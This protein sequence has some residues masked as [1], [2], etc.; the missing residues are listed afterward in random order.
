MKSSVALRLRKTIALIDQNMAN[1]ETTFAGLLPTVKCSDCGR[2][3]EISLM[4]EHIC[5]QLSQEATPPAEPIPPP[6]RSDSGNG[7]F[8][9]PGRPGPPPRIDPSLANRPFLRPVDVV[10]V[11]NRHISQSLTPSTPSTGSRKSYR[12]PIRSIKSPM[13]QSPP[14]PEYSNLD[15]A[16]PPFPT[17][18]SRSGTPVSDTRGLMAA[19]EGGAGKQRGSTS[20][21][22][23]PASRSSSRA[24]SSSRQRGLSISSSYGRGRTNT[25]ASNGDPIPRPA[26][27]GSNRRPSIAS[28]YSATG[29]SDDSPP[30]LPALPPWTSSRSPSV[31]S[32][33][34]S[35]SIEL[36]RP[37]EETSSRPQRVGG[38]GGMGNEAP[39][40][41]QT[42]P[43]AV[44][45]EGLVQSPEAENSS[46]TPWS[47]PKPLLAEVASKL[48]SLRRPPPLANIASQLMKNTIQRPQASPTRSQTF[49]LHSEQR[50]EN[51]G[52]GRRPSEPAP[53]RPPRTTSISRKGP[54]PVDED[55]Q[56]F[57]P[58]IRAPSPSKYPPRKESRPGLRRSVTADGALESPVQGLSF[59]DD[60]DIGNPYHTPSDSA[61]SNG[62]DIS[63]ASTETSVSTSPPR[64][65]KGLHTQNSSLDVPPVPRINSNFG[66]D[67]PTDP[68][69]QQGRLSPIPKA[70]TTP[71]PP[72]VKQ[73]S[74]EQI[75]RPPTRSGTSK[76]TCR[77]C[78]QMIMAGEK[79]V[80]SADGRLTGRYH[81]R[82]F[83]CHSCRT[84]FATADFYVL[85]NSPYCA[86][87]YHEAN[88][89][90]CST[91]GEGIEGQYLEADMGGAPAKFSRPGPVKP[92]GPKKYHPEC[93]TCGTC[94]IMLNED[95][96]VYG[97]K[98]FC[99]RDAFVAAGMGSQRQSSGGRSRSASKGGPSRA[100]TVNRANGLLAPGMGLP[101]NGGG[102]KRFPERRT[103][104]L[105]NMI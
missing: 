67:S 104:R 66:G 60:L 99:E 18:N 96:Y 54:M 93:F 42:N 8:L 105:M 79:S 74:P 28:N 71:K 31:I 82:C 10:P 102:G 75:R 86:K 14:S 25:L 98:I 85:N 36:E 68:L 13:P 83:V 103:T 62:S 26:T 101:L 52:P 22:V 97:G 72:A 20:R 63:T 34:D 44:A 46:R 27:A 61:S 41:L 84:P 43:S 87:H 2:Q 94:K 29:R 11:N 39:E 35:P 6:K 5:Q 50:P 58:E 95:Y 1:R 47:D 78:S 33:T 7:G 21:G 89:S 32:R 15:C 76:G 19:F 9:K 51:N 77:G 81:K 55:S 64:L 45:P 38:Y 48:G 23:S 30:P 80:S 53:S 49:P 57:K 73:A 3:I 65:A 24:T 4:G 40:P 92:V 70:D 12:T 90:L 56:L 17:S 37:A 59:A 69:F 16:F 100:A 91:C 88:G